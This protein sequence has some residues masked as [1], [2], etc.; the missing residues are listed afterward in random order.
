MTGSGNDFVFF[1]NRLQENEDIANPELIARLCDR[2]QGV[3]ADGV[4]LIDQHA[5]YAFGMRYYNRDGTLAEMC[6][7]AALCSARLALELGVVSPAELEGGFR[8]DT[9]SGPVGARLRGDGPE[10]D[11]VPVTELEPA[12]DLPL[13]SGELR[14]GFARV[15]VPHVVVLVDNLSTFPVEERGRRIRWHTRLTGKGGANANFVSATRGT[16]RMRTYERGVEAETLAC[17]TGSVAVAALLEVWDLA[18]PEGIR[19][20]TASG[21]A[22]FASSG[23]GSAPPF[24]RGEGRIVFSGVLQD[25]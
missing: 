19:I 14:I 7:N 4:V 12:F 17:G 8:F 21:C 22:V 3:G 5:Q 24:L 13:E 6:G 20:D 15:G 2:R 16:V 9:V 23:S 1:D 25:V 10:I 18:P 11:M